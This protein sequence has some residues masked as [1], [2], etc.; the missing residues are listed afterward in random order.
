M[1]F[2]K[3]SVLGDAGALACAKHYNDNLNFGIKGAR[4]L[5]ILQKPCIVYI[6]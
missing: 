6:R 5:T 4:R 3:V 1:R 2:Q